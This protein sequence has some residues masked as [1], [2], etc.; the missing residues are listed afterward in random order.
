MGGCGVAVRDM[1]GEFVAAKVQRFEDV[2]S[3]LLAESL[4]ARAVAEF[5]QKWGDAQL[6][7]EG[8]ALMVVA[9]IQKDVSA[10]F[11]QFGHIIDT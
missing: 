2:C 11:T 6:Q 4:A 3:P 8:D 9:S 10:N 5:A 1:R 7:L